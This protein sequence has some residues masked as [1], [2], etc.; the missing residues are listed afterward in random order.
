MYRCTVDNAVTY[1]SEDFA[2]F[3]ESP[4]ACWME[5]LTLENPD[6]GIPADLGSVPPGDSI[7]RQD[8]MADTL[9][10]EGKDVCLI[11]WDADEATRR[12]TTLEAM[13]KGADF[14]VNGQLALGPLSSAANL[15]MRTSGYSQLGDF[16]YIPCDTQARNTQNSAF[17][18]CFLADLLHSLQGQMPPQMLIIRGGDDLVPLQTDNYIYHYRA[19]KQLFMESMR[20]FRKH[21]MPDPAASSHFGRWSD[22]AHEVLKQRMLNEDD[23]IDENAN[24]EQAEQVQN[25][26]AVGAANEQEQET[27][28]PPAVQ[29]I[30]PD[31]TTALS[32]ADSEV[33]TGQPYPGAAASFTLA[34]QAR[35]LKPGAYKPGPGVYRLGTPRHGAV[36]PSAQGVVEDPPAGLPEHSMTDLDTQSANEVAPG[37]TAKARTEVPPG[38]QQST[39]ETPDAGAPT[40]PK[41][42]QKYN[43][44]ASDAAL[45][46]LEFIG[47]S[48]AMPG[49]GLDTA[50]APE[51]P[52]LKNSAPA[53]SLR[54]PRAQSGGRGPQLKNAPPPALGVTPRDDAPFDAQTSHENG[55]QYPVEESLAP[56]APLERNEAAGA[57]PPGPLAPPDPVERPEPHRNAGIDMDGAYPASPA[58]GLT[59]RSAELAEAS[60]LGEEVKHGFGQ[61]A[62]SSMEAVPAKAPDKGSSREARPFS[63]SIFNN[64]IF[65]EGAPDDEQFSDSLI[66]SDDYDS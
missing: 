48:M 9:R 3:R 4:F 39:G 40:P 65:T 21:R 20:G 55:A 56:K 42:T 47:S 54:D 23:G 25:A 44:R 59:T 31:V 10:A 38:E 27:L 6:H 52:A 13:R 43:R 17:R 51:L 16:L 50:P 32:R 58:P 66:T 1:T 45:Q 2:L 41:P 11:D 30:A 7:E 26:V 12:S 33:P 19:V 36:S 5:R 62:R 22:C 49:L 14:I 57:P 18:L 15:L 63:D 29:A 34:E 60:L 24:E 61:A 46:N 53:P 37:Y 8:D 64:T 28:S 35:M